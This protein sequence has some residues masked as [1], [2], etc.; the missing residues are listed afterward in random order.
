[1][2]NRHDGALELGLIGNCRVA[3]LVNPQARLMWWCYPNYD[4]DPVFSRLLAGDD[5]KGFADVVLENQVSSTSDYQRNTAIITT[6][7]RDDNG[8][9]VGITDFAPRATATVCCPRTCTRTPGS[10]GGTSRRPA[11]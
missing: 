5:E 6:V 8:G 2:T 10:C 9:A 4:S 3:A 11:P 7:L 1:M